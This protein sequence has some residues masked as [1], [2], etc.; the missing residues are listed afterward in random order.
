MSFF[1]QVR[2]TIGVLS[3]CTL[4]ARA[5]TTV[6]TA[7]PATTAPAVASVLT[8]APADGP[9]LMPAQVKGKY[10]DYLN[11]RYA[12]DKEARAAVHM[13]NRKQAGGAIWLIGGGAVLGILTSQTGTTQSSTGTTTFTISPLGY[14]VFAGLPAAMAISKFARFNNGALYKMLAEYDKSHALPGYVMGKLS[15]SDYR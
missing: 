14:V 4:A 12:T 15:K 11:Q 9:L 5:Q 3:V 10:K 7:P 6:P 8:P 2:F 13:F 1:T